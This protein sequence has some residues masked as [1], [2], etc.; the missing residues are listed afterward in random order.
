M[1]KLLTLILILALA[2]PALALA[3]PDPIVG[4]WYI[5]FD[6]TEYPDPSQV[7]GKEYFIYVMFFEE[8][9]TISG[10]SGES[11]LNGGLTANGSAIGSWTNNGSSYTLNMIG[12][13]SN[14]AEFSG[15][16]LLVQMTENVWYSMQKMNWGSW[17]TDLV[18]R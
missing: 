11:L 1:K 16:R 8:D 2:L 6:Y 18:I 10:V 12:I 9:G 4:G 15:D 7:D 13:G 5:M 17:Y 3:D 14:Q